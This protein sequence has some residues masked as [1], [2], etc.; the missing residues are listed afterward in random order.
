MES[1]QNQSMTRLF[2]YHLWAN[3]QLIDLC[4][5]PTD[6]QLSIEVDGTR[7]PIRETLIH[8]VSSEGFLIELMT[9]VTPWPDDLDWAALSTNGLIEKAQQSGQQLRSIAAQTDP[10][11]RHD[12]E[13]EGEPTH[14]F[15]WTVLLQALYH[16]IEHR[17]QIKVQLT[18]LG[19]EHPDLSA[20]D[21]LSSLS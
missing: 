13:V 12:I 20:W 5:Q 11:T 2:D 18:Q 16:G 6:E 3:T 19:I 21:Y 1:R 9:G 14:Y 8:L 17:T 7:G 10:E 15:D 4:S